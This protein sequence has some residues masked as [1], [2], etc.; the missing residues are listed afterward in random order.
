MQV[1]LPFLL[2]IRSSFLI[3]FVL[4]LTFVLVMMLLEKRAEKN[5]VRHY[6]AIKQIKAIVALL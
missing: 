6:E 1:I 3:A 2:L 4:M 5:V